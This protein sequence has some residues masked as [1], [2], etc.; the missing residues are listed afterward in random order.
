MYNF[1]PFAASPSML[2]TAASSI[3][4]LAGLSI[5]VLV[6]LLIKRHKTRRLPPSPPAWPVV[7][8]LFDIPGKYEWLTYEKWGHELSM[9]SSSPQSLTILNSVSR[10][11]H[12]LSQSRRNVRDRD[13]L[14]EG[15][16]RFVRAE[17][18]HLLRPV[19]TL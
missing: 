17:V 16:I 8:N 5:T 18:Q 7:G 6:S 1:P 3:D 4:I 10:F 14:N 15:C 19:R 12:G 2:I 13:K 11:R 9:F